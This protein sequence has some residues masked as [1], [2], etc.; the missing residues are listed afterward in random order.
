ME[1]TL[2]RNWRKGLGT[3]LMVLCT[4]LD[5]KVSQLNI[6]ENL[7]NTNFEKY[8]KIFNI[9]DDILRIHQTTDLQNEI[10]PSDIF[11]VYS[12]YY[13]LSNNKQNKRFIGIAAYQDSQAFENPGITYPES[14]YYPIQKYSELYK[15]LKLCGWEVITLDNRNVSVEEKAD[16]ISNYC[17]CVIG[18]EGGIAHLC[19]MLDVP[20]IMF[21]WKIP[22]DV[23][24]LHIDKK[25]FFLDSFDQILS[26]SKK[27]LD[28]CI[29]DL[30]SGITNNELVNNKKLITKRLTGHLVSKEEKAFLA[31]K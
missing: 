16:L 28:N 13:K 1:F 7:N 27:D 14:K 15:L 8:K 19:H 23:K 30:H 22:F 31:T 25:T 9:S 12:P 17:E 5:Y 11:K 24:L 21:P 26:W 3:E 10:E 29:S 20:Y 6:N 4:L 2:D 18:Y